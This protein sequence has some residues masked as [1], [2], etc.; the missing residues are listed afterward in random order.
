[1]TET[2]MEKVDGEDPLLLLT[3]R[4]AVVAGVTLEYVTNTGPS[5]EDDAGEAP[6]PKSHSYDA[7]GPTFRL[8]LMNPTGSPAQTTSDWFSKDGMVMNEA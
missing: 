1:M 3:V 8:V 2:V 4:D 5:K 6:K 7:N